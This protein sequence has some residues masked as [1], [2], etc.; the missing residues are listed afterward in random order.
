[1]TR[2]RVFLPFLRRFFLFLSCIFAL[3]VVALG[4]SVPLLA[5]DHEDHAE[6]ADVHSVSAEEGHAGGAHA[7]HALDWG[8]LS[9]AFVNFA[10]VIVALVV[11]LRKPLSTYLK[12]R[13]AGVEQELTD[14]AATRDEA[15]RHL[16]EVET[17]IGAIDEE[18]M[19][20]QEEIIAAGRA[21]RERLLVEAEKKAS[22]IR[23][24]VEFLI[25]QQARQI[26]FDL[27]REISQAAIDS[28]LA[29]LSEQM[30]ASD[31]D[32]LAKR[33]VDQ[34]L[35]ASKGSNSKVGG[36]GDP[37]AGTPS[38]KKSTLQGIA[39]ARDVVQAG[40]EGPA[41]QVRPRLDSNSSFDS[42]ANSGSRS[43]GD[44]KSFSA[45]GNQLMGERKWGVN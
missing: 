8:Q 29:L 21:E 11:L 3:S 34:L 28:A 39:Q 44:A 4:A 10:I 9:A 27:K 1:M 42:Q 37:F 24:D 32:R 43:E 26:Q 2:Q 6:E 40:R 41:S 5:Q 35:G 25:E 16:Q 14:A 13:R 33:F 23:K 18:V 31:R 19:R 38:S 17:R 36:A 22:G 20:L 7:E 45:T 12:A 30:N 15:S